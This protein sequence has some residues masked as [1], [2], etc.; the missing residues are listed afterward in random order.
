VLIVS[1]HVT[2]VHGP[3]VLVYKTAYVVR[4]SFTQISPLFLG[5]LSSIRVKSALSSCPNIYIVSI[6]HV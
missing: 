2:K 5:P 3:L 4:F 6:A 1:V